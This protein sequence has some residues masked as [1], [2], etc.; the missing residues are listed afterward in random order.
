VI[1]V[2]TAHPP[3]T[4]YEKTVFA[5]A[6]A[7]SLATGTPIMTHTDGV[8]GD[9]QVEELRAAGVAPDR[10]IVG[11]CC[12]SGDEDYH[13]RIA[14]TGAWLGFDR[15]GLDILFPDSR[16]IE[17]LLA[18]W[19]AGRIGQLIVSHDSVWCFRG[20]SL[21]AAAVEAVERTSHPLH[22]Q[23]TIAPALREA[24]MS[25]AELDTLLVDNPRRYFGG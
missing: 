19:R 11:H 17:C 6:A 21:P 23:R 1:K 15:F 18:L 10:V 14:A 2:G 7:A 3:I 9:Q 12:C 16:R 4:D 8:L 13:A 5:A 25:A 24:G 22:F 20:G